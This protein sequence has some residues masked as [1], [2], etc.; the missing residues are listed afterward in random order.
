M[1]RHGSEP[2]CERGQLVGS[3]PSPSHIACGEEDL[4]L[5]REQAQLEHRAVCRCSPGGA[6]ALVG[7]LADR[8]HREGGLALGELQERKHRLRALPQ[9]MGTQQRLLGSG[10]VATPQPN[11]ANLVE[12]H[13]SR[14]RNESL[15]LGRGLSRLRLR[16]RPGAMQPLDVR[17]EEAAHARVAV[18]PLA[19]APAILRLGPL[20]GALHVADP[21]AGLDRG[22]E[23]PARGRWL[24]LLTQR[25]ECR[26]VRQREALLDVTPREQARGARRHPEDLHV[27]LSQAPADLHRARRLAEGLLAV[28]RD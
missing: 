14:A 25:G 7:Q 26:L 22:A 28:A 8:L 4:G 20:E 5:G 12:G 17:A 1:G 21:R 3:G 10:Q 19:P 15:E 11:L 24:Q 6:R 27:A 18:D 13:A 9:R 16:F 23:D 2:T